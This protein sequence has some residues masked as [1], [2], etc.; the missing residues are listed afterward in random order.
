MK[1]ILI[2]NPGSRSTKYKV[3][4]EKGNV[5]DEHYYKIFEKKEEKK[6]LDGLDEVEKIGIRVVHGGNISKTSKITKSLKRKIAEYID[7][8]PIHNTRAIEVI[9][10][11]EK[12]FPKTTC[13]ACFDTA[14]HTTKPEYLSTYAIPLKLAK[15]YQLKKYGFHGLALQSALQQLEKRKKRKGEKMPKKI[16][17]AHLGGGASLTAVQNGKSFATTMGLTPL[18]GIP[19]ITRSG[20]VDPDIFTVLH[21]RARMS[22]D[23]ISQILNLKSGFYGL[24]GSKDT[25]QIFEKAKRG[26]KK[27]KLAF[28]IFVAEITEKIWGYAGL[29]QGIDALVFSGGIG[30]GNAY[31]RSEVFKRIKKLGL[32]KKDI[33][34]ID[35]DEE[36]IIFDEIKKL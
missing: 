9:E 19:M 10:K 35:V 26:S 3:F 25:L 17:F 20:S 6:F 4:D 5:L 28:D 32:R 14:F 2:I 36:R 23:E 24:T 29:M 30:Y 18:S 13:F 7:F 33:Y 16:V 27:E 8:A 31:L 11:M 12:F 34:V 1:K 21:R 15:K 22:V